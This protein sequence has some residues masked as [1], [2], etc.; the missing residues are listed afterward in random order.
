ML[1]STAEM[2]LSDHPDRMI[3]LVPGLKMANAQII[4]GQAVRQAQI[5]SPKMSG[6]SARRLEPIFGNGFFGIYFPDSVS[7][8]QDHGIRAFTMTSLQGKTVPMWIDDPTGQ[9]RQ[10][11]PKAKVRT[12]AS[13]KVQILIFRKVAMKGSRKTSYKIDKRSGAKVLVTKPASFPGA[14]GRINRRETGAPHTRAGKVAGAIAPGNSGVKWRHPGLAPRMFLNNAMTLAAMW[15]GIL[16]IRIYIA[17]ASS[18][19]DTRHHA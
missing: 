7:W 16:P 9:E 4:A 3:M 8:F 10:K 13:G 17:D 6:D 18:N 12:T 5:T 11:N 14:P 19:L 1:A 15:G 2:K